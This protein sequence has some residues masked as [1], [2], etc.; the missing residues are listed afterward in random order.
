MYIGNFSAL[1]YCIDSQ[2]AWRGLRDLVVKVVDCRFEP[3]QVQM[4]SSDEGLNLVYGR[5]VVLSGCPAR[6]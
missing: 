3:C 6:D 5:S 1:R 2:T 4:L